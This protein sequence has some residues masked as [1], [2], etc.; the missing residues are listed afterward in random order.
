MQ[1]SNNAGIRSIQMAS[2]T[3]SGCDT[4]CNLCSKHAFGMMSPI[5]IKRRGPAQPTRLVPDFVI[6]T[7]A[8]IEIT[9]ACM[10]DCVMCYNPVRTKPDRGKK[11]LVSKIV[12][13]LARSQVPHTYLIGGEPTYGFSSQELNDYVEE[14]FNAGSSVTIVTNGQIRLKNITSNLACFG[15]SLHGA[16]AESHDSITRLK[17][18]WERAVATARS[19]VEEGHDV[20][21]ISVVM[22]RNYDHMYRLAELAWEIGAHAVYYDI[23]EPGGIGER[24][25]HSASLNLEPTASQLR[26]AIS[27]ILQ[28][29]DDFPFRGSIGFGTAVPFCFDER[30]I[31]RGMQSACG[32]GTWFC[33][34]SSTGDLRVCNQS[35]TVFGN[36][37]RQDMP[38]IWTCPELDSNFR[39][40]SWVDEPCSSCPVLSECGGGCKVDEGCES[41]EFCIDRIVRGLPEET[42]LK[43]E[44]SDLRRFHDFSIP[45]HH[46]V[47]RTSRYLR[48][49]DQYRDQGDVFFKTRY[50]T[51]RIQGQ[52][53][54]LIRTIA[55][56]SGT[57]DEGEFLR[58]FESVASVDELRRFVSVLVKTGAVE[59]VI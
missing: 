55:S 56:T 43:L 40:L 49:V 57:F 1:P 23:Y 7:L 42:K 19:Y 34:I 30:L 5:S 13:R 22:G 45:E 31:E 12:S 21:I 29:K 26:D 59:V 9:Y 18:S 27:L 2:S 3:D 41:G 52:E 54:S 37:L 35:K 32:A 6:P 8:H 33:A 24:N 51:V 50:Q 14:L 10:E 36:V 15:V 4:T 11:A 38:D 58:S 28:A 39:D 47:L 46:R 17:G 53:E 48:V 20:R 25:S 16:D 44:K